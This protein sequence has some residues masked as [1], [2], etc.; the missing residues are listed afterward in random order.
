[1]LCNC[2]FTIFCRQTS[3]LQ[4]SLVCSLRTL[5]SEGY[6]YTCECGKDILDE[7]TALIHLAELVPTWKELSL[8]VG[9]FTEGQYEGCPCCYHFKLKGSEETTMDHLMVHLKEAHQTELECREC[10]YETD[11]AVVYWK[12]VY[13]HLC[14]KYF[15][16]N[17]GKLP[18]WGAWFT[19]Q[20]EQGQPEITGEDIVDMFVCQCGEDIIG[21]E[22]ALRH[23]EQLIP[24]WEDLSGFVKDHAKRK[25]GRCPC[26]YQVWSLT[27]FC[28]VDFLQSGGLFGIS[29]KSV[30]IK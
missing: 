15:G 24:S 3:P 4:H 20:K 18:R 26:C 2:C 30:T 23:L 29:V 12:H 22:S 7:E 6:G 21:I 16:A 25:D 14:A 11:S 28:S 10:P 17:E 13:Y 27:Q 9:D 19:W 8:Y 1:M 5:N